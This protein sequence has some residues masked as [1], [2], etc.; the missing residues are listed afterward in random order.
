M[1]LYY[2]EYSTY[3]ALAWVLGWVPTPKAGY[4]Y[5]NLKVIHESSL[6][7]RGSISSWFVRCVGPQLERRNADGHRQ[8]ATAMVQVCSQHFPPQLLNCW[9]VRSDARPTGD[10]CRPFALPRDD[11][12]KELPKG[13]VE[14]LMIRLANHRPLTRSAHSGGSNGRSAGKGIM[15]RR[16]PSTRV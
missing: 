11:M 8:S 9:V 3:L 6:H 10:R 12:Y 14:R 7:C 1:L 5:P 16:T 13:A 15:G 2:I 4:V